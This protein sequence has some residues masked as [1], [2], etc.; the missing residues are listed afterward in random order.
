MRISDWS[1]DVCSSD[2]AA[3]READILAHGRIFEA[4]LA[5]EGRRVPGGA[6]NPDRAARQGFAEAR[7]GVVPEGQQHLGIGRYRPIL[8]HGQEP[9][10]S[11]E[12]TS[13]LQSLMRI[14]YAVFC[15]KNK[16]NNKTQ[17]SSQSRVITN[18]NK[19]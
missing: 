3:D 1:S 16:H 15:L 10:R 4:I 17:V 6:V 7:S 13:E 8:P 5:E 2:L 19:T 11:E 9:H 14:S 18:R 12:H